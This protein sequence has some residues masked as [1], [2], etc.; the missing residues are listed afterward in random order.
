MVP[1]LRRSVALLYYKVDTLLEIFYKSIS[2][3][4]KRMVTSFIIFLVQR[5]KIVMIYGGKIS[6]HTNKKRPMFEF[7]RPYLS[8]ETRIFK[9]FPTFNV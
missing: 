6:N 7:C 5:S 1:W 4:G 8:P 9:K 3:S 2:K